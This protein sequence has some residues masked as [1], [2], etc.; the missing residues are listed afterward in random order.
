MARR[1]KNNSRRREA[2]QPSAPFNSLTDLSRLLDSRRLD[3]TLTPRV[4]YGSVKKTSWE[5]SSRLSSYFKQV[6]QTRA[7]LSHDP[8]VNP[9]TQKSKKYTQPNW[10]PVDQKKIE[11]PRLEP[12][13]CEQRQVRREV[14]FATN[15]AGKT[16]QKTPVWTELSKK[17]KCK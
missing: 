15:K 11:Q 5:P 3:R 17:V 10:S 9:S 1:S 14:L 13:I 16:G 7:N 6:A 12:S 4:P 8:N 2:R